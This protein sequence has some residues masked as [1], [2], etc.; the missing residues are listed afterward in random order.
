MSF[1]L[2]AFR[3][4][5]YEP[6]TADV[7]LE[8]FGDGVEP[9]TFRVR[10]LTSEELAAADE[11]MEKARPLADLVESVARAAGG[12]AAAAAEAVQSIVGVDAGKKP[13][14]WVK[15]ISYFVRG[16]IEPAGWSRPDAVKFSR[17]HPVE[18]RR[19]VNEILRLTG[20]GQAAK[21]KP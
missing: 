14:A 2:E 20:L 7:V 11:D 12:D 13:A 6:R 17:V 10:G 15:F 3:A 16:V 19:V 5:E 18:F 9:V 8:N 21:K 1:D 4:A